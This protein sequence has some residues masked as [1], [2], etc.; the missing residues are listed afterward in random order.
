VTLGVVEQQADAPAGLIGEWARSRGLEVLTL[1]AP[2]LEA[3][4][5]PRAF[6]AVAALGSDRSV[7]RSAD[8]WIAHELRFLRDAHGAGVPVLGICFGAQA[9]AAALGARVALAAAPEIG[10]IELE[11][12]DEPLR[13]PWFAW[14]EDAFELPDGARPL[15]RS[16]SGIHAFAVDA[17]VG[18]QFHPEVTPAIVGDWIDGDRG[19]L[20]A[21]RIDA[22]AL[23]AQTARLAGAARV[24][25]FALFDRVAAG[26][27]KHP[28]TGH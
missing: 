5:D 14:H 13:G 8:P 4:P 11:T 23:R 6:T 1:R 21:A 28:Q 25:A 9:L 19:D 15:A 24:R 18:V 2:E 7:A 10:W 20:A 17:S 27:A 22:T 12:A 3:W 16:P 26:W